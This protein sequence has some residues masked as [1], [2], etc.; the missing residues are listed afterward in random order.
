M[1]DNSTACFFILEDLIEYKLRFANDNFLK[2]LGYDTVE[3]LTDLLSVKEERDLI[4]VTRLHRKSFDFKCVLM[5]NGRYIGAKLKFSQIGTSYYCYVE[6]CESDTDYI[7]RLELENDRFSAL[8]EL[9]GSMLAEFSPKGV[10]S[11]ATSSV[12]SEFTVNVFER[13]IAHAL[14]EGFVFRSDIRKFIKFLRGISSCN[15]ECFCEVRLKVR[16]VYKWFNLTARS[17]LDSREHL[18]RV[19]VK[20]EDIE[21]YKSRENALKMKVEMDDLTRCYK[22]SFLVDELKDV[23]VRGCLAFFDIDNFKGINDSF[24]HLE[25][26]NALKGVANVCKAVFCEDG[27][28]VC[29]FGGDEFC[30]YSRYSDKARFEHNIQL[31]QSKVRKIKLCEQNPLSVSVGIVV[32]SPTLNNIQDL[33]DTADTTLYIVK[34][35]GKNSYKFFDDLR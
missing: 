27:D 33:L 1:D 17:I 3:K 19:I 21:V 4:S 11:F 28:I 25:G 31:M 30:I 7:K 24:G 22:K 29:R 23:D 35:N 15:E 10:L 34:E 6:D 13:G 32:A 5:A 2:L 9:S 14:F 16:D 8:V 26:D 18:S 12:L 20:A